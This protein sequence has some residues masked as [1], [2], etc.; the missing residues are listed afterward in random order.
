MCRVYLNRHSGI[1]VSPSMVSSSARKHKGV[2]LALFDNCKL[3]PTIA[4]RRRYGF[5]VV[6]NELEKYSGSI[7]SYCDKS[8][9]P[10]GSFFSKPV[11][12][13]WP[14]PLLDD[15]IRGRP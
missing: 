15:E 13:T 3:Q 4:R 5:P 6:H 10:P 12:R 11:L 14:I 2:N 8:N 1:S 9:R 7:L